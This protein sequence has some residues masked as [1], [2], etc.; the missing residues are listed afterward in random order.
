MFIDKEIIRDDEIPM[1][2]SMNKNYIST[3]Y[4]LRNISI[5]KLLETLNLKS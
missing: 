5:K 4:L 2:K 1:I 3:N